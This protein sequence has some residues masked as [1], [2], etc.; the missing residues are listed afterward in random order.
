[1]R[2]ALKIAYIGT[3]FHGFHVQPSARTIEGELFRSL[4]ESGIINNPHE[5][6]YI[7][8]GRTDQGVHALGQVIAFDTETSELAIPGLINSKLPPTIWAWAS[9]YVPEGFDPRH[10][11]ISREYRYIM[12]G[13]YSIS[14]LRN[15]SRLLKGTHDF[16]NFSTQDKEKGSICNIEKIE[17][18]VEGEFTIMDVQA[19]HF[20]WHMVRKIATAMKMVGSG[21][22]D[23]IWLEQML[24]PGEFT[25]GL[26]LSPAY[27]LIFKNAE[28]QN[29]KWN[30]DTSAKKAIKGHLE[31]QFLWHGVIAEMLR[32]LKE[33]LTV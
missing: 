16:A 13:K 18:R 22:R 32:E 2:V 29:I 6:G 24:N 30:E 12:C 33:S 25:E 4:A 17:T 8:A 23:I 9:A 11:A 27:G 1:M 21:A 15:A 5:A 28:F 19:D 26:E 3:D 20:L 10:N 31:E 7:S 14:L